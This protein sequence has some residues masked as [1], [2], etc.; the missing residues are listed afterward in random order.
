MARIGIVN[1]PFYS[2]VEAATRLGEVLLR[3]GHELVVWAPEPCREGVE[4]IGASFQPQE[5]EMPLAGNFMQ[6]AADM[7]AVAERHTQETVEEVHE[8]DLDVLVHD[9]QAVWARVAGEYLGL[10]R[11]VSHPM[12][13]MS[14]SHKVT[15]AVEQIEFE[16]D[17]EDDRERFEASWRAVAYRWGVELGQWDHAIH[18]AHISDTT[19]A[20]TTQRLVGDWRPKGWHFV[21][22]LMEKVPI[23]KP[24]PDARPLVYVCFG[25]SFNYRKHLFAAVIEGLADEPV[26]VL[27]S[28]GLGKVSRADLE[29]LPDNVVVEEFVKTREVLERASVLVTHSGCNSVHESLLAGVPMLSLPQAY[30][31]YPLA[32]RIEVLGAGRMVLESATSVRDGVRWLLEDP[33][34]TARARE[35]GRH[36]R[37]YDGDR[38]VAAVV[39]R[40]LAGGPARAV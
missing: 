16:S 31:Q 32:G 39:D 13:P 24:Q 38:R 20:Y 30:D 9:S 11:I 34:G 5:V 27:V 2:H 18:S 12:F 21:G 23:S 14:T 22:P 36:L 8:A 33:S 29:P 4:K 26:D 25:T 10:P 6:F 1:V 17:P 28:T 7:A 40:L 3:L 37:R 15:P 19:L 35:L